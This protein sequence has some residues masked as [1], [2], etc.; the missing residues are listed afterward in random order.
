M[1]L[2]CF[3]E[4]HFLDY[5]FVFSVATLNDSSSHLLLF[6]ERTTLRGKAKQQQLIRPQQ[7]TDTYCKNVSG[8]Q[9]LAGH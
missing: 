7:K 9:Q 4:F 1:A 3:I 8:S 2:V 5:L 6:P